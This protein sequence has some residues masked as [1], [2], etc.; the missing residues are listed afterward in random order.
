MAKIDIDLDISQASLD[1][2][3]RLRRRLYSI[4]EAEL[5]AMGLEDQ[6]KYGD[7]LH[8]VGLAILK[9]ETAKLK[10]VNNAFKEKEQDLKVAAAGL[11]KQLAELN[12]AVEMIRAASEG[13]NL[14]TNIIKLLA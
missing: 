11:E 7:N 4:P 1:S 14:V 2:L 3:R 9:L 12:D 5:S 6:V 8:Q 10:G 13:L